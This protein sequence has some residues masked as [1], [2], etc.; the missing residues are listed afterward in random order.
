MA[1]EEYSN[2][3]YLSLLL[4][5]RKRSDEVQKGS[6]VFEATKIQLAYLPNPSDLTVICYNWCRL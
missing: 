5:A 2:L 4:V 1:V 3:R 6:V